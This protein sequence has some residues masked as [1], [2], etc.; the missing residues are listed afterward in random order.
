[1]VTCWIIIR[2]HPL[3]SLVCH[4]PNA[5][6]LTSIISLFYIFLQATMHLERDLPRGAPPQKSG[7]K[8][9]FSPKNILFC[10]RHTVPYEWTTYQQVQGIQGKFNTSVSTV[11]L[12]KC[13]PF[14]LSRQTLHLF[15]KK[16]MQ[17]HNTTEM[18]WHSYEHVFIYITFQIL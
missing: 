3:H 5:D 1:M 8:R 17:Y 9:K 16:L 6:W 10:E 14:F 12:P 7:R 15:W 2:C 11:S 13:V 18:S 4:Y